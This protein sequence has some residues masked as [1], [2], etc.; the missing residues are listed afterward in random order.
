MPTCPVCRGPH[1][2]SQCPQDQLRKQ[3]EELRKQTELQKQ[4]ARRD[5]ERARAAQAERRESARRAEL[6]R[7]DRV[8][9]DDARVREERRRRREE[10]AARAEAE[11][12]ARELDEQQ[13]AYLAARQAEIEDRIAERERERRATQRKTERAAD[14]AREIHELRVA[15]A[16]AQRSSQPDAVFD[17][18]DLAE[19]VDEIDVADVDA[20]QRRDLSALVAEVRAA[21]QL[22][23]TPFGGRANVQRA[24]DVVA[25]LKEKRAALREL[26]S[27]ATNT[28]LGD[29]LPAEALSDASQVEAWALTYEQQKDAERKLVADIPDDVYARVHP[30]LRNAG[31]CDS[32]DDAKQAARFIRTSYEAVP[33]A[34]EAYLHRRVE[35]ESSL[36]LRHLGQSGAT[37]C[38]SLVG[39]ALGGAALGAIAL[40]AV[41]VPAGAPSLGLG[42]AACMVVTLAAVFARAR[43]RA[44]ADHHEQL[45]HMKYRAAAG[46]LADALGTLEGWNEARRSA[47]ARHA[48]IAAALRDYARRLGPLQAEV[49]ALEDRVRQTPL[50]RMAA[51]RARV[52][53]G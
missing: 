53:V 13:A 32:L 25:A 11:E 44:R 10:D 35:S 2:I 1:W 52:R 28:T 31:P 50:T 17:L 36:T 8:R 33:L 30:L 18:V 38:L 16:T 41:G 26:Q 49:A 43:A 42:T 20:G 4:A 45:A 6:D 40:P 5:E 34:P 3:T 37:G 46:P 14:A 9:R 29:A 47:A 22:A 51:A 21:S 24:C 27:M 48:E 23:A 12:R 19:R 7:E 15:L 39:A